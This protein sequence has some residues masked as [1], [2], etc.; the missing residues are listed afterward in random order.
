MDEFQ[1]VYFSSGIPLWRPESPLRGFQQ[2][3][4]VTQLQY[5]EKKFL[6]FYK[7]TLIKNS[8]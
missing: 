7:C 3:L 2:T 6:P 1:P 4:K 8:R 5:T